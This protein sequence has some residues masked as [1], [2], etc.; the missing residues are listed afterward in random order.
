MD[1]GL[2]NKI[3]ILIIILVIINYICNGEIVNT[4]RTQIENF[5]NLIYKNVNTT[6]NF[7]QTSFYGRTFSGIKPG[8][9]TTPSTI[10]DNNMPYV[11]TQKE[12]IDV[13]SK[14]NILKNP[15]IKRLYFF[16][17]SMVNVNV[18]SYELTSSNTRPIRLSKNDSEC[19]LKYFQKNFNCNNFRFDNLVILDSL[20]YY[21]NPRGKELRPFR[22]CAD[23]Y[24]EN[25][26]LGKMTIYVEMFLRM[27]SMFYGPIN[28]GFPTI[29]RIK[30][31]RRDK[32][33]A[34]LP[35]MNLYDIEKDDMYNDNNDTINELIPTE[36]E[37]SQDETDEE[38][39]MDDIM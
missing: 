13:L 1:Y 39:E 25:R 14:T 10:H 15:D 5:K 20:I 19:I 11:Y 22:I 28:A 9:L 35:Q 16:L 32:I 30:L 24:L 27:D 33:T 26:P 17:H 4:I 34:P 38:V 7:R 2:I 21:E 31:I 18:N 29:T 37:I 12:E 8:H 23:V 6:E 3:L 36:I